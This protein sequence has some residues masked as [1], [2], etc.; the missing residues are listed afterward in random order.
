[1]ASKV[2]QR[3][4]AFAILG[5]SQ[6]L[7]GNIHG[8]RCGQTTGVQTKGT[9]AYVGTMLMLSQKNTHPPMIDIDEGFHTCQ[10]RKHCP[11]PPVS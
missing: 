1:M 4:L 6:S 11:R 8:L 7:Y 9:V 5:Y 2:F 10:G 3:L